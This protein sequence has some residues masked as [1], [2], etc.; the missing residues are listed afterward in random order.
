LPA[1]SLGDEGTFHGEA[2][3]L[4]VSEYEKVDLPQEPTAWPLEGSLSGFGEPSQPESYRCGTLSGED[5]TAVRGEAG[6]ANELTPWT[7]GGDRFSILFRPLLPDES[8]C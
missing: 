2:A 1:G 8:G 3:R 5:W 4:F 6:R 7:D